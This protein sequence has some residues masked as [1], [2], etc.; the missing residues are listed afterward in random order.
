MKPDRMMLMTMSERVPIFRISLWVLVVLILFCVPQNEVNAL[1]LPLAQ[2]EHPRLILSKSLINRVKKLG[3]TYVSDDYRQV[4]AYA[5]WRME[6]TKPEEIALRHYHP[7]TV[8]PLMLSAI[9][10]GDAYL[11]GYAKKTAICLA[12]RA[13]ESGDDTEQR[14]RLLS[15]AISYDWLH[16][17]LIPEERQEV[18]KSIRQHVDGLRYFLDNP[19]YTGGHGRFGSI[20]LLAAILATYGE[21]V[22]PDEES[23]FE[24]IR[25]QWSDGYNPY[26]EFA[27]RD[28]GYVMGWQ[29]GA[30]YTSI[31]PYM[32]GERLGLEWLRAS[33]LDDLPLWYLYGLRGDLTFPKSG[34]CNDS[35]IGQ[36][37]AMFMAFC[38]SVKGNKYA[39]WFYRT[40]LNKLWGPYR[41][42]RLMFDNPEVTPMRPDDPQNPLPLARHFRGSG[43][44]LSRDGWDESSTQLVFKSSPYYTLNHQ[45]KD[46]NHFE[47]S[48][49]GSLLIDSGCYDAYGSR[50]WQNYYTRTIAH[51]TLIEISA[52]EE[53]ILNG[54]RLSN[55]GG[56]AFRDSRIPPRGEEPSSL[57]EALSEKYRLDGVRAFGV[58]RHGAWM[59]GD[60]S[61]AYYA[62]KLKSYTREIMMLNRPLGRRHPYILILDRAVL[63][64][65]RSPKILFHTNGK[66]EVTGSAFSVKNE[67][68]GYLHGEV[69]T[70]SSMRLSLVGGNGKE[71]VVDGVNYPPERLCGR[72]GAVDAGA[73]RIEIGPDE[74]VSEMLLITVLSIDDISSFQGRPV[75]HL[76]EGDG[77]IGAAVEED[78]VVFPLGIEMPRSVT[79]NDES[80]GRIRRVF[81]AGEAHG[82]LWEFRINNKEFTSTDGSVICMSPQ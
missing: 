61:K 81:V 57:T 31:W 40:Y 25:L 53:F 33:W 18:A 46:Q 51:N 13:P 65:R 4:L 63:A 82:V 20:A 80:L 59:R 55:D 73:W 79:V 64:G 39:E 28:G 35:R 19:K 1:K 23:L 42:W 76:V 68:G 8:L 26:Q 58:N 49:K 54:R 14:L 27:A 60:A 30:G 10:T 6:S 16:D 69:L 45:H 71:W 56:Q 12:R 36:H 66:P 75:S 62:S 9:V 72:E 74:R 41:I 2:D 77:F 32:F 47:L 37:L 52:A 15:L 17:F 50:H 78:L 29:Y 38:A 43:F 3:K 5:R 21:F 24:K 34:D 22:I 44:V 70:R 11:M 7:E 48:Y 67:A